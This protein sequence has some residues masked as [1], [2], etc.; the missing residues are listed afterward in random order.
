MYPSIEH[1]KVR[2]NKDVNLCVT[3]EYL[4]WFL[5]VAHSAISFSPCVYSNFHQQQ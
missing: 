3:I 2:F 5:Y 4:V 1:N